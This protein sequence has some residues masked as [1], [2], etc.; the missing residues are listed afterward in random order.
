MDNLIPTKLNITNLTPLH[1]L[2][3]AP[4]RFRPKFSND[5]LDVYEG[6]IRIIAEFPPGDLAREAHLAGSLTAQACTEEI[7]LPPADLELPDR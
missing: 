1:V 7:C 6:T 5:V 2:Y 3:P 4:V